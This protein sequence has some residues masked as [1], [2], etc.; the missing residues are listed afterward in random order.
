MLLALPLILLLAQSPQGDPPPRILDPATYPSPAATTFLRVDPKDREGAGEAAVRLVKDGKVAFDET[1]PYAFV[2]AIVTDEGRSV[3]YA[4]P[5]GDVSGVPG[6]IVVAILDPAG[7]IVK[8]HRISRK[9]GAVKGDVLPQPLGLVAEPGLD[10][11]FLRIAVDGPSSAREFWYTFRIS[12]GEREKDLDLSSLLKFDAKKAPPRLARVRT[13]PDLSLRLLAFVEHREED[14][15]GASGFFVL[16]DS[17]GRVVWRQER[18]GD[19]L[20][21]GDEK[22][23]AEWVARANDGEAIVDSGRNGRVVLW[24]PKDKVKVRFEVKADATAPG[25]FTVTEV[26]RGTH[27]L[28]PRNPEIFDLPVLDLE[29]IGALVLQPDIAARS[30]FTDLLTFDSANGEFFAIDRTQRRE[31]VLK[32]I[33]GGGRLVRERVLGEAP[34]GRARAFARTANGDFLVA[35]RGDY[36]TAKLAF[37]RFSG[38][39]GVAQPLPFPADLAEVGI[40]PSVAALL[41]LPPKFGGGF[42]ALL[43]RSTQF[44]TSVSLLV[45]NAD[46]SRRFEVAEKF[47][48]G[49]LLFG[50]KDL[51]LTQKGE[52]AVLEQSRHDIKIFG[53]DG[54]LVRTIDLVDTSDGG[55]RP[56]G[57]PTA[58]SFGPKGDFLVYDYNGDPPLVLFDAEGTVIAKMAPRRAVLGS[59]GGESGEGGDASAEPMA[60]NAWIASDD[61]IWTTDGRA[62]FRLDRAGAIVRTVAAAPDGGAI[63]AP[64]GAFIDA[65]GR[66]LVRDD[67]NKSIHVFLRDGSKA[68]VAHAEE[69]DIVATRSNAVLESDEAGGVLAELEDGEGYL[70]FDEKGRRI[71]VLA[72]PSPILDA[73]SGKA[74]YAL[75]PEGALTLRDEAGKTIERIDRTPDR[76]WMR[77][78]AGAALTADRTVV[79]GM[80]DSIAF[81]SKTPS[82]SRMLDL[83]ATP[84]RRPK[85]LAAGSYVVFVC[86]DDVYLLR[87]ADDALFNTR[88]RGKVDGARYVYGASQDGRYL[89]AVELPTL[90][91]LRFLL[92]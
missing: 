22:A 84:V 87:T 74:V 41:A 62:F 3:G 61:S 85:I 1:L 50:A 64:G 37:V 91:V 81:L 92:P 76:R 29:A 26:E 27:V 86:G 88:L 82:E 53:S 23:T 17:E 78:L 5:K 6:D 13:L 39:T 79:I 90:R 11:C 68:F 24:F 19:Y 15:K 7:G 18:N 10:R 2:G 49:K 54:A 77:P 32:E 47:E 70:R 75:E 36:E 51:A 65:Y 9:P 34:E 31:L 38:T 89:F 63:D 28:Q 80:A 45:V 33:D 52:L 4:L 58:L 25:G 69:H 20:V 21:A 42:A 12:S 56:L 72:I 16:L 57:L 66:V 48:D 46:G 55:K 43:E 59:G 35:L 14:G 83:S 71:G 44:T 40:D 60:R 8:E 30:L 73:H 67:A